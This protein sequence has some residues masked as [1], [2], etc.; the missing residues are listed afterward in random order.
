MALYISLVHRKQENFDQAIKDYTKEIQYSGG[1][2]VKAFNNRAYCFAKVGN[3]EEAIHDY[4]K[5][6]ESDGLNIHALHNRGI[7]YEKI[8]QFNQVLPSLFNT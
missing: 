2:N 5:V 3:Y 4:S 1:Q 7:S 8:G 6:V